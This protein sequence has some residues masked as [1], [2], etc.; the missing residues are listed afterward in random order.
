[1]HYKLYAPVLKPHIFHLAAPEVQSLSMQGVILL[2]PISPK[3]VRAANVTF[4]PILPLSFPLTP[5][6]KSWPDQT[7]ILGI[8]DTNCGSTTGTPWACSVSAVTIPTINQVLVTA[9]IFPTAEILSAQ[10]ATWILWYLG[11]N[12][13]A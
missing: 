4:L 10:L 1:M 13:I 9:E 11:V 3:T 6:P 8:K 5:L 2:P 7:L 12:L